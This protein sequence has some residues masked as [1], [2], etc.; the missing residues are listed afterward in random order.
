MKIS[1]FDTY[2]RAAKIM[3]YRQEGEEEGVVGE[4]GEEEEEDKE[5]EE[6][7]NDDEEESKLDLR[8]YL[9]DDILETV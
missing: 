9:R 6:K 3:L 4:G 5:T 7:E 8:N 1:Q 2:S